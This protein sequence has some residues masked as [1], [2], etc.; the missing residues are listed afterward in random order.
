MKDFKFLSNNEPKDSLSDPMGLNG[1][2]YYFDPLGGITGST[3]T[4]ISDTRPNEPITGQ[5][6]YDV[7]EDRFF[8]YNGRIWVASE[9]SVSGITT[10]QR[11]VKSIVDEDYE[12]MNDPDVVDHM[13]G[14]ILNVYLFGIVI[15]G[16]VKL[17]TY[18][19]F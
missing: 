12:P 5:T 2:N 10:T 17:F 8:V 3:L 16:L 15:T 7:Y 9:T 1:R 6:Y 13:Q 4:Y 18:A 14:F 19:G 11:I